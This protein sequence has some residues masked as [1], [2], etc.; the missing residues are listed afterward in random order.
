MDLGWVFRV[1]ELYIIKVYIFYI[2]YTPYSVY[3]FAICA[4]VM[5][6]AIKQKT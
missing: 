3:N 6:S 4:D 2:I 1:N 5:K